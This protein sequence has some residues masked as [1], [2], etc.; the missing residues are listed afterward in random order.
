MY[1][2]F[3]GHRDTP[4]SVYE[5]LLSVITD[6]VENKKATHFYVGDKGSFDRMARGALRTLSKAYPLIQYAVVLAY[7]PSEKPADPWQE[8][9]DPTLFPEGLENVSPRYAIERRNR[10]MVE[11]SNIVV[12]YVKRSHGGAAKFKALALRKG[13]TVIELAK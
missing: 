13:K 1:V 3:F 5:D 11:Q 8:D 6:L 4:S 10:F 12:T 9:H 7:L 2:T